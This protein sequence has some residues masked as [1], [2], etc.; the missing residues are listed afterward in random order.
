MKKQKSKTKNTL[1]DTDRDLIEKIRNSNKKPEELAKA[2]DSLLQIARPSASMDDNSLELAR[3]DAVVSALS[4]YESNPNLYTKPPVEA[5]NKLHSIRAWCISQAK[6]K[7][8]EWSRPMNKGDLAEALGLDSTKKLNTCIDAGI[9]E[10]DKKITRELW[11]IRIDKLPPERQE[12][13]R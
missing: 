6:E 4:I 12:K 1:S 5:H 2:I 3:D 11:R 13:L 8:K 9:Y 7:E 10:V